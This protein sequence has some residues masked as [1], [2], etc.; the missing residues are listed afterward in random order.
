MRPGASITG[1]H[2]CRST[3]KTSMNSYDTDVCYRRLSCCLQQDVSYRDA[4]RTSSPDPEV[5]DHSWQLECQQ[6]H[7]KEESKVNRVYHVHQSLRHVE[8]E[9]LQ[10]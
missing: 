10:R 5:I 7:N 8:F 3:V 2:T 9:A 6:R 1:T 4:T